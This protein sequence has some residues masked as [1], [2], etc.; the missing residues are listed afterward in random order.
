[1]SSPHLVLLQSQFPGVM[2][3]DIDQ[4]ASQLRYGRGHLYNLHCAGKLPFKVSRGIGNKLLVSVVEFAAYL[5]K[6]SLSEYAPPVDQPPK[7]IVKKRGRPRGSTSRASATVSSFQSE[8]R[9]A[10]YRVQARELLSGIGHRIAGERIDGDE[11]MGCEEQMRKTL[12]RLSAAVDGASYEFEQLHARLSNPESPDIPYEARQIPFFVSPEGLVVALVV[13]EFDD[14][15]AS[16][17][18]IRQVRWMTWASALSLVW[19]DESKRLAWLEKMATVVPALHAT[20]D[21]LRRSALR[22]I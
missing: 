22:S 13:D 7:L 12:S 21:A 11:S 19:L 18:A 16:P 17:V 14:H 3:L 6:T 10:I 15:D 8:L 20:V 2:M 1:M 4:I 5:D 9:S